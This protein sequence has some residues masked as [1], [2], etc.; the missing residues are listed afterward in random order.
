MSRMQRTGRTVDGEV[1]AHDSAHAEDEL[2]LA[3]LM[4]RAVEEEPRVSSEQ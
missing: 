4:D 3:R 2:L 1:D